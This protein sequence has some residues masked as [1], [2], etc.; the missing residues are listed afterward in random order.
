MSEQRVRRKLGRYFGLPER[1]RWLFWP[2][3]TVGAGSSAYL[4]WLEGEALALAECAP[5]AALPGMAALVYWFNHHVFA[6][7]RPR[8]EDL[9]HPPSQ[10]KPPS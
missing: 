6:S 3:L 10:R 7:T 2:G 8:R 5:V 1:L 9:P 4:H